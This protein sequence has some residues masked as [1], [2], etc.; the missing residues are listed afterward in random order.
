MKT[1]D[2]AKDA[3][4]DASAE[5]LQKTARI[6]IDSGEKRPCISENRTDNPAHNNLNAL[7]DP[8]VFMCV[9]VCLTALV[10]SCRR[11]ISAMRTDCIKPA[12]DLHE[13]NGEVQK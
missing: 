3:D 9:C 11:R 1:R 6:F 10:G 2:R 5:N 13:K 8:S 12:R 7:I 4:T